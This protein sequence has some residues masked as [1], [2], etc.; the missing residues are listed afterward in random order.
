MRY[1]NRMWSAAVGS[2][3]TKNAKL[4]SMGTAAHVDGKMA[5]M[6]PGRPYAVS[7]WSPRLQT[8]KAPFDVLSMF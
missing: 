4:K 2:D 3:L 1:Y 7:A 6:K 8:P 5:G